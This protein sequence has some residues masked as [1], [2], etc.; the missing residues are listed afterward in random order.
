MAQHG[1]EHTRGCV[2]VFLCLRE[3]IKLAQHK[4]RVE[5]AEKLAPSD[6]CLKGRAEPVAQPATS[7]TR[8]KPV[9]LWRARRKERSEV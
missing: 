9:L 8:G 5:E 2:N 7:P 1:K 3:C 4:N 6:G